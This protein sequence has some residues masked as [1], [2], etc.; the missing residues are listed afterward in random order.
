MIE[1]WRGK[2]V[3]RVGVCFIA[4]VMTGLGSTMMN[5]PGAAQR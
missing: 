4:A 2:T 5:I 3:I 1:A